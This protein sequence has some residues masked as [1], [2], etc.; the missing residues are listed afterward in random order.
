MT[1]LIT[2]SNERKIRVISQF[3]ADRINGEL[4]EVKDLNIKKGFFNRIRSNYNA[5]QSIK[6]DIEPK[7]IDFSK[8]NL[9]FLGSPSTL[10]NPS[11]AILTL[12]DNCDFS[13]KDVII[14]TTTNSN[15]GKNVLKE[16]KKQVEAKNGR[17]INSFIIRVNNKDD[18][19]LILATLNIF[20][21]SHAKISNFI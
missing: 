13:N 3:I 7:S 2:Y 6:T 5:Y 9:I 18:D 12:I 8:Y 16:M 10:G 15:Q 19:E 20:Y 11:P 17:V 4:I 21:F 1:T 14:Y